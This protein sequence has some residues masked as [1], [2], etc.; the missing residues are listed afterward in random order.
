MTSRTPAG[1]RTAESPDC[2]ASDVECLRGRC[3]SG[4]RPFFFS[5]FFWFVCLASINKESGPV[6]G[7][8]ADTNRC[9]DEMLVY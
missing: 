4:P 9:D 3:A 1:S 7:Q 6:N 2:R 5:F 8:P